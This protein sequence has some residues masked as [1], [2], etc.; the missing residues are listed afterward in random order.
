MPENEGVIG[1]IPAELEVQPCLTE[2]E[3]D[4]IKRQRDQL[5]VQLQ[6]T[7]TLQADLDALRILLQR[8]TPP[9]QSE[10][11]ESWPRPRGFSQLL[12]ETASSS[13]DQ[14]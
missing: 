14:T 5:E 13:G 11:R 12:R 7:A 4:E 8:P 2:R 9:P 3:E 1:E 10:R 6:F